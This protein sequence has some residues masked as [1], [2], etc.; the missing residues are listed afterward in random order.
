MNH[1]RACGDGPVDPDAGVLCS[2]CWAAVGE[3]YRLRLAQVESGRRRCVG[4]AWC[5]TAQDPRWPALAAEATLAAWL[6]RVAPE[7]R[8]RRQFEPPPQPPWR[9]EGRP[10]CRW[11]WRPCLPPRRTWCS[12]ACV[13]EFRVRVRPQKQLEPLLERQ[14][15]RC[16][17]CGV[18]FRLFRRWMAEAWYT[19]TQHP[20]DCGCL[21]C[22]ALRQH[23]GWYPGQSYAEIH[24]RVP[25]QEGGG[26][27][28]LDGLQV[29]CRPCHAAETARHAARRAGR[30]AQ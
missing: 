23:P 25:V 8:Y 13:A 7:L 10:A 14:Q 6:A 26:C 5:T 15:G 2:L 17:R 19:T 9:P 12:A 3:P 11:C 30:T 21:G 18:D 29:L 4:G 24:H 22:D 28:G 20:L 27:C 16:E 1:C